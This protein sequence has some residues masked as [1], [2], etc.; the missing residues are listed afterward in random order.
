[1]EWACQGLGNRVTLT[2]K[3]GIRWA[4]NRGMEKSGEAWKEKAWNRKSRNAGIFF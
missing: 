2:R 3:M 1:M 4:R